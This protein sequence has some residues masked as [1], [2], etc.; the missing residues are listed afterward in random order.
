MAPTWWHRWSRFG[1]LLPLAPRPAC[2]DDA[3]RRRVFSW[4]MVRWC[5]RDADPVPRHPSGLEL[6]PLWPHVNGGQGSCQHP[7]PPLT[8]PSSPCVVAR[9][10]TPFSFLMFVLLKTREDWLSLPQLELPLRS[11][12]WP[13]GVAETVYC[14]YMSGGHGRGHRPRATKLGLGRGSKRTV[15]R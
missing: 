14:T 3:R 5:R 11:R 1:S 13:A 10:H 4:I 8:C 12:R 9:G 7:T 2:C 15:N 6:E